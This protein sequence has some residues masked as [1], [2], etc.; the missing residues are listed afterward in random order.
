MVIGHAKPCA[1]EGDLANLGI[2]R[3][4]A[5]E[6]RVRGSGVPGLQVA[7]HFMREGQRRVIAAL[8][9]GQLDDDLSSRP[10]RDPPTNMQIGIGG[11]EW[12]SSQRILFAVAVAVPVGISIVA[13][14]GR[15]LGGVVEIQHCE[16][17][18]APNFERGRRRIQYREGHGVRK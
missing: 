18:A 11:V 8:P 10:G 9:V 13:P 14:D 4:D 15:F 12:V 3:D 7:G 2:D 1:S 16:V 6:H 5:D 17:P